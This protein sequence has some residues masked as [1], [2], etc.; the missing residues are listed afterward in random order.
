MYTFS[1]FEH[2]LPKTTRYE[3]KYN[4]LLRVKQICRPREKVFQ[5]MEKLEQ[6]WIRSFK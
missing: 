4:T 6:K 2:Q 3:T 1:V 5:I